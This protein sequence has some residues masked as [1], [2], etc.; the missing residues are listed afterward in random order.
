MAAPLRMMSRPVPAKYMVMGVPSAV[1]VARREAIT[2]P[3]M[4]HRSGGSGCGA[5]GE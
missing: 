3:V 1:R 5:G 2:P 4:N